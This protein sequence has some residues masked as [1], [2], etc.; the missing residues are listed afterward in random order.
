MFRLFFTI[1]FIFT[2]NIIS[3]ERLISGNFT[4]K[5][6]GVFAGANIQNKTTGAV[7]NSDFDGNYS[8]LASPNDIIYFATSSQG[9]KILDRDS[10]IDIKQINRKSVEI[11]R[12]IFAKKVEKKPYPNV[13]ESSTSDDLFNEEVVVEIKKTKEEILASAL[14]KISE[15]Y[16][17]KDYTT[18]IKEATILIDWYNESFKPY[19]IPLQVLTDLFIYKRAPLVYG[20]R[21]RASARQSLKDY[22]GAIAD[23]SEAIKINKNT[24]P[25]SLMIEKDNDKRPPEYLVFES[26]P[27]F[28][29]ANAYMQI[30]DYSSALEDYTKAID[31]TENVNPKGNLGIGGIP[32][33]YRNRSFAYY[34]LGTEDNNKNKYLDRAC[35]DIYFAKILGMDISKWKDSVCKY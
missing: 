35:D 22:N 11:T 5:R 9:I 4:D 26:E 34:Y 32:E 10:T 28:K 21:M 25:G 31:L 20:Y 23:Y 13:V 29:R 6:G 19:E 30:N 17:N 15:A 7:T 2:V 27:F 8:I 18:I 14:P 24:P 12:R 16:N 3:Q 33:Y 1:F